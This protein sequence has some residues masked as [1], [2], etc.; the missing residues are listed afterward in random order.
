MRGLPWA[1]LLPALAAPVAA[2]PVPPVLRIE[3]PLESPTEPGAASGPLRV[4][5]VQP[6]A[7]S[8]QD[9]GA[10]RLEP[11]GGWTWEWIVEAPGSAATAL[12]VEAGALPRRARLRFG[13]DSK[14]LRDSPPGA[15]GPGRRWLPLVPGDAVQLSLELPPGAAPE[16]AALR[17]VAAARAWAAPAGSLAKADACEI[18]V[19]CPVAEPWQDEVRSV[20]R[21]TYQQGQFLYF[22][23]GQLVMDAD[24]SFRPWFLTA[25]HCG[26]GNGND[27]GVVLYWNF[28][29]SSC[30]GPRDG[31]VDQTQSGTIFRF[32]DTAADT[33]LLELEVDPPASYGVHHAG[34]DRSDAAVAAAVGIHHPAGDEK[35]ISFSDR[36]L[37]KVRDCTTLA[38]PVTHWQVNGWDLGVTEGGSSGSGLWDADSHRLVGVLTG[39]LSYCD[40]PE[41]PDCY[42]RFAVAWAN[43][44]D[45]W[46]DPSGTGALGVDGA[47]PPAPCEGPDS[48]GDGT[49][50]ACDVCPDTP[51]PEQA[52][53]DG[54]G[55][56]DLCDGCVHH[57]DPEQVDLDGDGRTAGCDF[58]YGDLAPAGA[59][60]G[61]LDVA[62]VLRA[63]RAAVDLEALTDAEF[64]AANVA[65]AVLTG[66]SPRLATPTAEPPLVLD[67]GDVLLT[68]QAAVGLIEFAEPT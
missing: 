20:A 41:D 47:D 57:P 5:D 29:A 10:W 65:P 30:G 54:D 17:V 35:S 66:D 9:H 58:L 3:A 14:S 28:E 4:A 16:T 34:W 33:T 19:A 22:C 13:A 55:V 48:D 56:G 49:P 64:Q 7:A 21:Y 63:L 15:R 27:A 32:S 11:G 61:R 45:E 39:G 51:D 50:D 37:T 67:V 23:T 40:T 26:V 62:D 43:G 52:D 53:L 31:P 42:G 2:S 38:P 44:L 18:D 8:A 68:L 60:D 59:P 6:L 25:E 1:L 24:E 12:A 46:L 36:P